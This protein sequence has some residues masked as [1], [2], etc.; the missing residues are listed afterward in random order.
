MLSNGHKVYKSVLP[1]QQIRNLLLNKQ[2]DSQLNFEKDQIQPSSIDL[3]LGSKA[4]RMRASF[5]P[6]KKKTVLSCISEFAMQEIDL[7][8]GYILEKGSVYL[9]EL[10]ESLNLPVNI[11]GLSN[12]KS[13]TGRLDVFT[14]LIGDYCNEFDRVKKGYKGPLYAEIVPN[15]FSIFAKSSIKLNQIRFKIYQKIDFKDRKIKNH[16]IEPKNFSINLSCDKDDF[17]GYRAKPHTDLIDLSKINYYKIDDFWEKIIPNNDKIVLDPG[18]FYILS[19]REFVSIAPNQAAEMAPYLPMIGEFR[20][21]YAGFF[22]PGFGYSDDNS[23]RSR[24]VL[25]V[26]CHE[27]PFI[28]EHGQNMG[29]L[30]FENMLEPPD[31]LYGKKLKSNYQGQGLKLSKHFKN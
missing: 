28:L 9:V 6:G 4:W 8:R 21:H 25:E 19:S 22:D 20:V 17:I 13:S 26:R 31:L 2:I 11:E 23:Q 24:A 18:A 7:S 12:A 27:T 5:L 3:R 15:S 16:L 14:R 29:Q 10:Q 30:V 1:S